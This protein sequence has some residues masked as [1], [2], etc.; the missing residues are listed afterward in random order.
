M[1]GPSVAD[2]ARPW[3][4][5]APSPFRLGPHT[6]EQ[7]GVWG[8]GQVTW[9]GPCKV[10]VEVGALPFVGRLSPEAL[11]PPFRL[12]WQEAGQSSLPP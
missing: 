3:E 10:D 11:L 4:L 9:A 6:A 12:G 5:S 8:E 2:L 1:W 7:A